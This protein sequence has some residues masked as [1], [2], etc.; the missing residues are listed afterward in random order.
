M[1]ASVRVIKGNSLSK[2]VDS[3]PV[4]SGAERDFALEVLEPLV[5]DGLVVF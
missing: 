2:L 1:L 5:A 4:M 3:G